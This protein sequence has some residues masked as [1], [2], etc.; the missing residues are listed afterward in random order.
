MLQMEC[1]CP[2]G[3]ATS[4]KSLA[5]KAGGLLADKAELRSRSRRTMQEGA[6]GEDTM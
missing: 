3:T 1:P 4:A 6:S 5:G 2:L